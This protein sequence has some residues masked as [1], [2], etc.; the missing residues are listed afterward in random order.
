[1]R[2]IVALLITVCFATPVSAMPMLLDYRANLEVEHPTTTPVT[3]VHLLSGPAIM[4][5]VIARGL[6]VADGASR[7]AGLDTVW[8]IQNLEGLFAPDGERILTFEFN[9]TGNFLGIEPTPFFDPNVVAGIEPTPFRIF[10]AEY[11]PDPVRPPVLIGELD[12][13]GVNMASFGSINGITGLR[14][15]DSGSN[16]EIAPFSIHNLPEAGSLTLLVAGLPLLG[17]GLLARRSPR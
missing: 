9:D 1:M 11:P 15:I 13:R 14:L 10:L 6:F 8:V 16:P 4:T 12:F 17:L 3:R 2:L 7:G 5:G